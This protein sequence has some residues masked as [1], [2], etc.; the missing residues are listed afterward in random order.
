[1]NQRHS[2]YT[3]HYA[4]NVVGADKEGEMFQV[5]SRIVVQTY[6]QVENAVEQYLTPSTR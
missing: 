1:M 6:I 4:M 2:T 5:Q 3:I